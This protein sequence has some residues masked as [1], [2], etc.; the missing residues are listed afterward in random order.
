MIGDDKT[1]IL[2][3]Q[4][5]KA[6]AELD[7]QLKPYDDALAQRNR[8]RRAL[9]QLVGGVNNPAHGMTDRVMAL[10]NSGPMTVTQIAD[11]LGMEKAGVSLV[12]S[13]KRRKGCVV[14]IGMRRWDLSATEK[15]SRQAVNFGAEYETA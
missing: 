9:G 12:L 1:V 13:R 3:A 11:K 10:L 4:L 8:L 6:I 2:I 7:E 5:E 14:N 15:A